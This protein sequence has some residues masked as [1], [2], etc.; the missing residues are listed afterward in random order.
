MAGGVQMTAY[1]LVFTLMTGETFSRSYNDY[2]EA[3][4]VARDVMLQP[5][6]YTMKDAVGEVKDTFIRNSAIIKID[7]VR[8]GEWER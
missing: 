7:V 5:K 1:K 8:V 4:E 3:K 6:S 2:V